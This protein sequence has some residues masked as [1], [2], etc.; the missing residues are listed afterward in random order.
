[1]KIEIFKCDVCKKEVEELKMHTNY[2]LP[3]I[4]TTDQTEGRS[5]KPYLDYKKVDI[6]FECYNKMIKER[7]F[8]TACGAQGYFEYKL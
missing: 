1:M 4:F 7:K 3:V 6:C 2:K 8:V 5:R